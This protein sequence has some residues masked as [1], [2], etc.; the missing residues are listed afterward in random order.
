MIEEI[1]KNTPADEMK[2]YITF[3]Q[4]I[5]PNKKLSSNTINDLFF[6]HNK[7]YPNNIEYGQHC[8]S[9]RARVWKRIIKL[10]NIYNDSSNNK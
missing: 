2:R 4:S 5:N 7:F 6:I 10:K 3:I 9:C 8:S 1:I